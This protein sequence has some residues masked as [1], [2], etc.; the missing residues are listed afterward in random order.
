ML[1]E[2]GYRVRYSVIVVTICSILVAFF[3]TDL[4][5]WGY[6]ETPVVL[7]DEQHHYPLGLHVAFLEDHTRTLTI[8]DVTAPQYAD[9]FIPSSEEILNFGINSMVYWI[10]I[11]IKNNAQ[12]I[13]DWRLIIGSSYLDFI[14]MYIPN[15]DTQGPPFI[16][17][18]S[19]DSVP[20]HEWDMAHRQFVFKILLQPHTEQTLYIRIENTDGIIT[21]MSLRS[22]EAFAEHIYHEQ[23]WYGFYFGSLC[24]M[25]C[26]NLFIFLSLRDKSYLYY[27]LFVLFWALN[28]FS[29]EGFAYQYL[30]P[31]LPQWNTPISVTVGTLSAFFALRF[32]AHFLKLPTLH[33]VL[34]RVV[35]LLSAGWFVTCGATYITDL[36]ITNIFIQLLTLASLP[37]IVIAPIISWRHGYRPARYLLLAWSAFAIT[38]TTSVLTSLAAVPTNAILRYS[39]PI[40]VILLMLLLSWALA[41]RINELQIQAEQKKLQ[42]LELQQAKNLAE[43]ANQAKSMF[44]ANMSHELRT[45]L[46]AILGFT[47][48]IARNPNIPS[49]E[50]DNLAIIQRSG[51]HLLTLINQVLTL[52]KIEAGRITLNENNF[53]LHRLLHDVHDMFVFNAD[54][55]HLQLVFEQDESV[56]QHV[57]TDEVKLRQVLINLLSNALKFTETGSVTVRVHNK[58]KNA[59][60]FTTNL[61]FSISDTGP[62]IA[63]ED[64]E[65]VFDA[66]GQT[67]TG[68]GSQE[69]TGLGLPISRQFVNLMGGELDVNSI[70]GQGTTFRVQIPVALVTKDVVKALDLQA[71]RRATGIEPGQTAP[72]GGPFRLLIVEDKAT[73][74]ELLIK[75]LEPFGFDMRYAVNG[76]EGVEMWDTWQPHLVWMDMRM[77]VMDGYEATRQIK[78]HAAA[79]DRLAIVVALTASAFEEDRETI[80]AAGCDDFVRKPFREHKIFDVL[81]R[82]LGVRF[83]YEAITPT[84]EATTSV[85]LADLSAALETLPATWT[86]ELYE[87]AVVLEPEQMLALIK[88]VRPQAPDLADTL[89]QWV[90]DFEYDKLMALIAPDA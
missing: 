56:P 71:Q 55:K 64:M 76:A 15:I 8:D 10:R 40:G 48:V 16:V 54:K 21:R 6:D 47:Q 23:L 13:N 29:S 20:F 14:E 69:G 73:N 70:V 50:H 61:Q 42:A 1:V 84:P 38:G 89:A 28:E 25:A 74:R 88:A 44:L 34:N 2:H 57:R 86:A 4:P 27:V 59:E 68:Q 7:T 26:Y 62:G 53:D 77:P 3:L 9:R 22:A 32:T 19:G 36:G 24:I 81:H 66:F 85:S 63:P 80:L 75:L 49:K 35:M 67:T 52:S 58:E 65:K 60:A 51:E 11:P 31:N 41:D 78:A 37:I 33:P 90:R 72:D 45:P 79:T 82:H 12:N 39:Y 83:I 87:A 17:K 5:V 43:A 46:N 18:H 30:W